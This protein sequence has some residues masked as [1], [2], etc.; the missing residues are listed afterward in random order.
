M[1][2]DALAR[3]E[4]IDM[5]KLERSAAVG[6]GELG[7]KKVILCK[8]VTFMNNS[9]ESV[10]QLARFYKVGGRRRGQGW[11]SAALLGAA[12][13]AGRGGCY[14]CRQPAAARGGQALG[15]RRRPAAAAVPPPAQVPSTQVLVIS[16]D[17]DQPTAGIKLKQRGGHGG[18]NGLRSI[19]QHFQGS[20]DFPRLKIGGAQAAGA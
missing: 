4:G 14:C 18:H 10:G 7:G 13:E 15:R 2:V 5:R 19:M 16:D 17:L 3:M 8:P 1:V 11:E 12:A 6:K 20:Q 9:G